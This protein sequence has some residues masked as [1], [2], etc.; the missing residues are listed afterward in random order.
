VL[1]AFGEQPRIRFTVFTTIKASYSRFSHVLYFLVW[2]S[3]LPTRELALG[4][5]YD[6]VFPNSLWLLRTS[7][8]SS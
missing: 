7:T 3:K 1:S 8:A 2:M 6:Y 5:D 4:V